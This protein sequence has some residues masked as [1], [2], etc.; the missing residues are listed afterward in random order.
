MSTTPYTVRLKDDVREALEAEAK[1]EDRPAAQLAAQAIKSMLAS[2][3]AKRRS[4]DVALVEA[5]AG[6]FVSSD[7]MGSWI[8]SW[9]ADQELSAPTADVH[10]D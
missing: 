8:E 2:K 7:A 6:T 10:N 5:D 1:L 4:I 3:A 9:G